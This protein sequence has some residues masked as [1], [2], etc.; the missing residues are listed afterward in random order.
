VVHHQLTQPWQWKNADNDTDCQ[1]ILLDAKA[2]FDKVIHSHMLRRVY[3]AGI[4]DKHWV[5]TKSLHDHAV[6][7][8]KWADQRSE[9]F[10]VNQGVRQDGILST[11]LYKLYINLLL[12]RVEAT[13][14]GLRIG[15]IST[16]STASADDVAL[17]SENPVHTQILINMAY[18]YAYMEGYELQPTKRVALNIK[19]KP[20]KRSLNTREFKL[21]AQT[22][23]TAESAL[24]LGIIRT[25][26]LKDNMIKN[27]E[28][29]I[30]KARSVYGLFGGGYRGNNGLDPDTLINLFKTYITPV[31]VYGM[32]LII[33]KATPL[34][35]LELFQNEC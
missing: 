2:T 23:P 7:F 21:G 18:D 24:H 22:M 30:K 12:T 25:T 5:L 26:S 33:P 27:V 29:N 1:I 28:E 13:N 10:E 4:D 14:I 34:I 15:N 9:P 11:D 32:E 19:A 17:L 16:N 3:Q 8:V 6:S 20:N 35:Q 31:L